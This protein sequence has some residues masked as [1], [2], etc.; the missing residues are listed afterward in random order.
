MSFDEQAAPVLALAEQHAAEVDREGRFPENAVGA[1]RGSGLLRLTLPTTAGGLG[2]T[3]AD[4][5]G[6][7]R[8]IASRC[9]SASDDLPDARLRRA[10]R[11]RGG[12]G[13]D[14]LRALADGSNLSTLAFSEQGSRSHFWAPVSK[15][16]GSH[17]SAQKS[18]VTSAGHAEL[19]GRDT[20]GGRRDADRVEPTRP[21]LRRDRGQ[22]GM[23]RPRARGNASAPMTFDIEVSDELLL[24]EAG[25]GLD[26]MLGVVLHGSSWDRGRSP[27]ASPRAIGAAVTH[28]TGAKLEHLGQVLADLPMVRARSATPRP[29]STRW[30]GSSSTSPAGWRRATRPSR[31]SRRR[32]ARTRWRSGSPPKR[33]TACAARR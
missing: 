26:L 18:F 10:G 8:A 13:D 29:R 15:L 23:A 12:A 22:R 27:S 1:L 4:F 20:V 2:G 25:K 9:A 32:R 11:P 21:G 5:L 6:L 16:A 14:T 24:G 19:R 31:S 17:L 30:Q 3:P 33:C 7:T 28:V